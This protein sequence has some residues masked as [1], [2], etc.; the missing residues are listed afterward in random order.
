MKHA[1]FGIIFTLSA[2]AAA[3]TPE[4]RSKPVL[5]TASVL[6]WTLDHGVTTPSLHNTTSNVLFDLHGNVQSCDLLLSTEGNYHMALHDIWPTFL[7]KFKDAP[8]QNA[9]YTTSPPVTLEQI[10][11]GSLQFD[12]LTLGCRP[13]VAVA[14]KKY[15]EKLVEGGLTD[16]APRPLYRD[17]GVV[18]LVKKGNPKHIHSV[19]DLGKPG[20]RLVTPNTTLETGAYHSYADAIYD[21][22]SMDP[23]PPKGWN[24]DRLFHTIFSGKSG[25]P[26][27]WLQGARIHHRDEPWS[28]A[29][30]KADAAVILYHLGRYTK[31]IFPEV[32]DVIP[33]GGTLAQPE[34]LPGTKT[35]VR[36]VVALKGNWSPKQ[37]AARNALIETL[38][39]DDFTAALERHG[40]KRPDSAEPAKG[41]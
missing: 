39:S 8:L 6:E 5:D 23:H 34:P 12:N 20:I 26:Y 33:L 19:W 37:L 13:S 25:D 22:A 1:I 27:K 18:I 11:Q 24:A 7:A 17:Q 21:I 31:E 14:S 15:I 10:K 36:E 29:Y 32:F 35:E 40:L 3:T 9:F 2:A 41:K 28:V 30:G 4:P 38:M 16:G